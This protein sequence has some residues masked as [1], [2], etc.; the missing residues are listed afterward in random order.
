MDAFNSLVGRLSSPQRM[1][2]RGPGDASPGGMQQAAIARDG[3]VPAPAP[4][5][6]TEPGPSITAGL[7]EGAP[8]FTDV[9][10][11]APSI[12][13]EPLAHG[14]LPTPAQPQ[15]AL[16]E[17]PPLATPTP[18]EMATSIPVLTS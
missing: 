16:S 1:G 10:S 11:P 2:H 3:P 18:L 9:P 4:A 17:G 5:P 6:A 15:R 12:I 13:H 14:V 7:A 8:L